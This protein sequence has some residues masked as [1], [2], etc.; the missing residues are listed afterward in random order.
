ML[1]RRGLLGALLL[2]A[3]V[4]ACDPAPSA[5]SAPSPTPA[6]PT[7]GTPSLEPTVPPS[8][9]VP[10]VGPVET[11]TDTAV[12]GKPP[13]EPGDLKASHGLVEASGDTRL[14]E[15]VLVTA[16]ACSVDAIPGVQVRDGA[17]N[18]LAQRAA[19]PEV[20]AIVLTSGVAYA[21][22]VQIT[23]WCIGEQTLPLTLEIMLVD[24]E[25]VVVTGSSFPDETDLPP[26]VG[27]GE[28]V[29]NATGWVAT[30]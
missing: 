10:T 29:L 24:E 28:P 23:N 19:A 2:A 13:C 17:G 30:P 4:I 18:L 16:A 20:A 21:A 5:P 6:A 9:S 3:A 1:D 11:P 12:A 8:Q 14:T 15:V 22:E 7:L 25:Y 26:C 27:A